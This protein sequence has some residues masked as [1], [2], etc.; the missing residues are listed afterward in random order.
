MAH[1]VCPWW[2]GY[3]LASPVR[4]LWQQPRSIVG[5]YV[6]EGMIVLEP[7]PGMGFFTFELARL[8]GPSGRV[9]AVDVQ[10]RMLSALQRRAI[11]RRLEDRIDTRLASDDHLPIAD[12][13][14][15]FDFVLAF[16]MVHEVS[17]PARFFAEVAAALKPGGKILV[18]EP[19]GHVN[20]PAFADTL[21]LAGGH[22]LGVVARPAISASHAAV[23]VRA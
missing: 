20:E 2:I 21:R 15:R 1:R 23:L 5:P 4:K 8:V 22:G 12:L 10:A 19:R 16:A 14:G 17:D 3:L 13:A 9:V 6:V 18:A 11:R 7:G